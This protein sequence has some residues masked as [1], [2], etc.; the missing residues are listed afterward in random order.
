MENGEKGRMPSLDDVMRA[1]LPEDMPMHPDHPMQQAAEPEGLTGAGLAFAL[2]GGRHGKVDEGVPAQDEPLYVTHRP[3]I[4]NAINLLR[5][6]RPVAPDVERVI[7]GL[8]A[9]LEGQPTPAGAP[10]EAW[11]QV[12]EQADPVEPA[13]VLDPKDLRIDTYSSRPLA[14][15]V[16]HTITGVRIIHLPTGL[17]A[18]C[19]TERSQ[20]ANKDKALAALAQMVARRQVEPA[21]A[22]GELIPR[23]RAIAEAFR[24]GVEW[25]R[26]RPAQTEQQPAV[27]ESWWQLIHDTLRNYRMG[28]LDDGYGGGYPLIDA[29]TADGQPVSGGIGECTY[30]AD[31]ICNALLA[32]PIVQTDGVN[33]KAVAG[34]QKTVIE[35]LQAR[36]IA[37]AEQPRDLRMDG[38]LA[39]NRSL[40]HQLE[41]ERAWYS[42]HQPVAVPEGWKTV[43]MVPTR[44]MIDAAVAAAGCDLPYPDA[45][46]AITASIVDA[47]I[48]QTVQG[49]E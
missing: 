41:V 34:E 27:P 6:R 19:E 4:R 13:P 48:A 11:L 25:Q 31:A 18:I 44:S 20:H 24:E 45:R 15:W 16:H 36:L 29:M 3:L 35:Q 23:N 21:P 17:E 42:E 49:G 9:M 46:G 37:Q 7:A 26:N 33:W 10:S 28:T 32:A 40:A 8:E 14:S 39:A 22:Q 5:V 1:V 30:L 47:P 43:P 12:A 38:L 2:T